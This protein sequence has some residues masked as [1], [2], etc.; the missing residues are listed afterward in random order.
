M[1][2]FGPKPNQNSGIAIELQQARSIIQCIKKG[3]PQI[4]S[5][6]FNFEIKVDARMHQVN[7]T[8]IVNCWWTH[9]IRNSWA[10]CR[11]IDVSNNRHLNNNK[12]KY[13]YRNSY[14]IKKIYLQN[15][16]PLIGA[17]MVFQFKTSNHR[18][19]NLTEDI[20]LKKQKKNT[21]T[22]NIIV[23]FKNT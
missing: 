20:F 16:N 2:Y 10:S 5:R 8:W 21:Y 23:Y 4:S 9:I 7:R 19:S 3:I 15:V 22:R 12:L 1:N 18:N 11:I 13:F 6:L 14:K 17:Q